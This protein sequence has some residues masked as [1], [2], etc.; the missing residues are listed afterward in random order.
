MSLEITTN[1]MNRFASTAWERHSIYVLKELGLAKPWT[2]NPIFSNFYF[3]NVFRYLDKTS[4]YII[5]NA[6]EPYEEEPSLWKTI[7]MCRYI[8]RID[9]LAILLQ[10]G[11][12]INNQEQAYATLRDMQQTGRRIFTNAFIVNSKTPSGW[13][14]KVTYLFAL[15]KEIYYAMD[16][17]PD[18]D[19]RCTYKMEDLYD[20]LLVLPGV[21]PFMA[22]QYTVDFTYSK[23][24]LSQA[25][26]ILTWTALGLGA[27]RGM[28]RL[29]HGY[30]YKD[31]IKDGL[32]F[33]Y[34]ILQRWNKIIEQELENE[35][36]KTW[37]IVLNRWTHPDHPPDRM[38]IDKMYY[39]FRSL[40]M[41]DVQHWLCEYDKYM[42]GGSKKRRY[43][44]NV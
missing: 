8:S 15:L 29:L 31:K 43:P 37:K 12:L 18:T 42:R 16:T 36:E 10:N 6:I 17:Q 22:Y 26:D 38:T 21:G 20:K 5:K 35:I 40:T 30:P 11:C 34:E 28:N 2:S 39:P 33:A 19:I 13:S 3:C 1:R 27:V 32:Q 7:I 41:M 23:R 14:D 24:Y 44:G 9:T 4:K 25:W